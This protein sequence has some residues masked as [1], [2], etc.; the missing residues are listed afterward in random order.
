M[1]L[2]FANAVLMRP[3]LLDGWDDY[4]F[5]RSP[6][7]QFAAIF[8]S[9][10]NAPCLAAGEGRRGSLTQQNHGAR[11]RIVVAIAELF[12]AMGTTRCGEAAHGP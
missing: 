7:V 2:C 8:P 10:R 6:T 1:R 5:M 9:G 3:I 4:E 12:P 11:G